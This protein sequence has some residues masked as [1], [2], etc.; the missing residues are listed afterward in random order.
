MRLFRYSLETTQMLILVKKRVWG[1][2]IISVQNVID[3][4]DEVKFK[5]QLV[6]S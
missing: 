1:K 6:S 2:P 5:V 4:K 3:S